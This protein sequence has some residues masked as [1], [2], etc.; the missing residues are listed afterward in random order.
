MTEKTQ[1]SSFTKR[2]LAYVLVLLF[3]LIAPVLFVVIQ[4]PLQKLSLLSDGYVVVEYDREKQKPSFRV[5]SEKPEGWTSYQTISR[6]GRESIV[7][8]E[9]W[10]FFEHKGLDV[11]QLQEAIDEHL[12]E[13]K[14]LRGASTLSQQLVKNLFLDHERS[15]VRKGRELLITLAME[16]QLSK[17]KILEVYLNVVE[18][19]EGIY[20]IE[21]ASQYYFKK[22]SQ[23]LNAKES[24]FL[25]M[26]LPNPK[27]YATSFKEKALTDFA[28][29]TISD[30]MEKRRSI[31]QLTEEEVKRE[32]ARKL[33]FE[34]RKKTLNKIGAKG[35]AAQK[36][37][38]PTAFDDGSSFEKRYTKDED[39]VFNSAAAFDPRQLDAV[40]IDV[41]VEFTLE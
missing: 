30:I 25:A 27:R 17:E 32:L 7:I 13:G 14:K 1:E 12:T 39:L 21:Q 20:G 28:N 10:A 9:D 16:K 22:S 34:A 15:F 8:S 19:G 3:L 18:F 4:I 37:K 6:H 23:N 5:T 35:S 24:A 36:L 40:D 33:N 41:D 2:K 29:K 26:L 31:G 38:R 11:K